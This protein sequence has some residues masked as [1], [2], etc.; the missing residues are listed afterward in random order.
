MKNLVSNITTLCCVMLLASCAQDQ[1]SSGK[2][3]QTTE[4]DWDSDGVAFAEFLMCTKGSDFSRANLEEMSEAFG[5]L[6][7]SEDLMWSGGYA[8]VEDPVDNPGGLYWE[9]NWTSE[10]AAKTAWEGWSTNE[11]ARAW[12]DKYSN[13]FVCDET[14]AFRYEGY[15]QAPESSSLKDWDSFVAA[16]I[17]CEYNEGKSFVDLERNIKEFRA[18]VMANGTEDEFSFGAYVPTGEDSADFWWYNWQADFDAMQRG[19]DNWR[20]KGAEMQAKFDET[21]TCAEPTPYNGMEFYR[22]AAAS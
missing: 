10:A 17:S 16:E 22:A 5:Q 6:A 1:E 21:A 14:Q 12:S 11:E 4:A 18:W 3:I 15:F 2:S 19:N 8:P 9:N 7:L 13:V 20:A